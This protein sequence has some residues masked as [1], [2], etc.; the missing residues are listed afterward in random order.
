MSLRCDGCCSGHAKNVCEDRA[1]SESTLSHARLGDGDAFR[2]LTDPYRRELHVHCYRILRSVQDAEDMV[3]ETP[4]AAWRGP[5]SSQERDSLG[6]WL[7]RIATNRCMSALR[8]RGRRPREAP[9][10]PFEL[11][12]P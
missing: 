6:A 2:A 9:G 4:L 8:A 7:Y 3:Q 1:V 10:L 5:E 11:P 12:E